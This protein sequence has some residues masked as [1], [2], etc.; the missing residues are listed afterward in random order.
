MRCWRRERASARA[1]SRAT[2]GS[3]ASPA[4][5]GWFAKLHSDSTDVADIEWL[6]GRKGEA[7]SPVAKGGEPTSLG[8]ERLQS[9]DA[10][11]AFDAARLH[12][13][14]LGALQSLALHAVLRQ[15]RLDVS[16]L[17]LG[18]AGG[19]AGGHIAIDASAQTPTAEADLTT[20]GI[21]VESLWPAGDRKRLTGQLLAHAKLQATGDS[22]AALLASA[23][24]SLQV[25]LAGA[26][27]DSRLD[28]ELGLEGGKVLKS[29]LLGREALPLRCATLA[30]DVRAGQGHVRE[31][32]YDS[33][34]TRVTGTGTIDLPAATLDIVLTPEAKQGGLFDLDRSIRLHGPLRKPERTLVERAAAPAAGAVACPH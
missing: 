25:S 30:L 18:I 28:A 12:A 22:Q 4:A 19:H 21:R 15:G 29:F 5:N 17:D 31:L 23:N 32:V 6:A 9:T 1:T 14:E 33:E 24:G 34:R 11:I 27:V 3:A 26:G 7:R 8:L 16:T 13:A 10:D 2:P 20:R